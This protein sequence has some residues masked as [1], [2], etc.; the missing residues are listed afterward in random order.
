MKSDLQIGDGVVL[1]I[2]CSLEIRICKEEE[3]AH[4]DQ[5]KKRFGLLIQFISHTSLSF[6]TTPLRSFLFSQSWVA[7][8]ICACRNSE[9]TQQKSKEE[10]KP[11]NGSAAEVLEYGTGAEWFY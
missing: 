8:S 5:Q 9:S 7:L 6:K 4:C 3:E 1:G 10:E 2:L 11:D